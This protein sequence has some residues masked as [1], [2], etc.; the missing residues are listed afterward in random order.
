MSHCVPAK[1][2]KRPSSTN[3]SLLDFFA[4]KQVKTA[5]DSETP[6]DHDPDTDPD[7]ELSAKWAVPPLLVDYSYKIIM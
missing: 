3:T 6:C 2:R 5:A 4:P 7:S 1:S